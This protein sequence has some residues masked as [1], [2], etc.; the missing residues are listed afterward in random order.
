M[1]GMALGQVY[2]LVLLFSFVSIVPLLQHTDLHLRVALTRKTSR[3]NLGTFQTQTFFGR[4]GG[5]FD[6]NVLS[7]F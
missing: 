2:L 4:N 6:K 3:R 7:M 5:A 1:G